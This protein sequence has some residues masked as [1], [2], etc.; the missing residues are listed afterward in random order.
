MGP[1]ARGSGVA[2]S[3]KC[4]SG[5]CRWGLPAPLRKRGGARP[6]ITLPREAQEQRVGGGLSHP[7][8]PPP[9]VLGSCLLCLSLAWATALWPEPGM[10]RPCP[11]AWGW[12]AALSLH[13]AASLGKLGWES[14]LP[15]WLCPG[16]SPSRLLVPWARCTPYLLCLWVGPETQV[17]PLPA[18][19][20]QPP[21]EEGVGNLIPFP[22]SFL[23]CQ[24]SK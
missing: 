21:A 3:I 5:S 10:L 11:W 4:A 14:L 23:L 7:W 24:G 20:L 1:Q 22:V 13:F 15:S 2:P 9:P 8:V 19:N 16:S 17:T 6:L 12:R 18:L